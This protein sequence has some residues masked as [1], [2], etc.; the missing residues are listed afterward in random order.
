MRRVVAR[1]ADS[2][3]QL[4][5]AWWALIAVVAALWL[6]APAVAQE[7]ADPAVEAD[8]DDEHADD[9]E[10]ED[11]HYP[12]E[13]PDRQSWSFS[14][15]FGTYEPDQ[16]QRGLQV[17]RQVCGACHGL[18]RVAFRTL[19]SEIGPFLSEEQ[20][21]EIA[22]AYLVVDDE[23]GERRAAR[24]ADH[25]PGSN[26]PTAPDLS[27]MTKARASGEGFRWLLDPFIQYQ[28]AGV[29]YMY[30]LL[31]GYGQPPEGK[32]VPPGLFYNPYFV[33]GTALSMPPPLRDGQ[34]AYDDGSPETVEQYAED[35]SAFLMWAAE[36][37]LTDRKRIGFQVMI[38]LVVF[39][40][41]AYFAKRRVWSK[42]H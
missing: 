17:Y 27:L 18:E 2:A 42:Q 10:H 9:E 35:V 37:K 20:M 22:E 26:V 28:E 11:D 13:T 25:F 6:A 19:A 31:T 29:D 15:P 23:T 30:A 7:A 41:L 3:R 14:G 1:A 33:S 40:A 32:E 38:F 24:P 34:V 8:A 36:P 16:L 12:L 4:C 39:A 21:R 5:L